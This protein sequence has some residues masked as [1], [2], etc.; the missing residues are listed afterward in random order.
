LLYVATREA[1]RRLFHAVISTIAGI[2]ED[3]LELFNLESFDDLVHAGVSEDEDMRVF[4]TKWKGGDVVGWTTRLLFLTAD[5]TLM[6]KWAELR[7][8]LA[9]AQ[10]RSVIARASGRR[11]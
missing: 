7:A 2:H 1:A 8:E 5:S 9:V 10:A 11:V 6:A 4:E 3:E